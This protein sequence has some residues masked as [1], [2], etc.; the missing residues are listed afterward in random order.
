MVHVCLWRYIGHSLGHDVGHHLRKILADGGI[1]GGIAWRAG[2]AL[3]LN[4][5]FLDEALTIALTSGL[6][7]IIGGIALVSVPD[8]RPAD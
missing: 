4:V 7:L 6:V 1:D 5:V 3:I 8:R 2:F